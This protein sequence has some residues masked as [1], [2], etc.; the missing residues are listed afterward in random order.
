MCGGH[1]WD[2]WQL[3][4]GPSRWVHRVHLTR[5]LPEFQLH[6]NTMKLVRSVRSL[7]LAYPSFHNNRRPFK[8]EKFSWQRAPPPR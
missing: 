6:V 1:D 2:L 7:Y 4:P 8:T 3:S 5:L